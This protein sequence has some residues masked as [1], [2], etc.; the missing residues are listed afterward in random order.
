LIEEFGKP[1]YVKIDIE[2]MD[3]EAIAG[4]SSAQAP[5]Y[6]SIERPNSLRNQIEAIR[7]LR[8][9]G[10]TKFQIVDQ[11]AFCKPDHIVSGLFG[12]ELPSDWMSHFGVLFANAWL[13]FRAGVMRRIPILDR[14]ALRGRW[15]DIHAAKA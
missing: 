15:F 4:L 8:H 3:N 10:Y 14:F 6:L 7:T 9:L 13:V 1:F 12:T 2:G 11:S 5:P